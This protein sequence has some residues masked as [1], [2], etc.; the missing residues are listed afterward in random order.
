MKKTLIAFALA[1][2]TAATASA[3][4]INMSFE[5]GLL[6][7]STEPD[8]LAEVVTSFDDGD[9]PGPLYG[10]YHAEHFLKLTSGAA[11]IGTVASNTFSLEAGD[12]IEGV[13]AFTTTEADFGFLNDSASVVIL[14]H[15]GFTTSVVAT[16]WTASAF[17]VGLYGS[18][19]WQYWSFTAATPGTYS[20]N[21]LVQNTGDTLFD[22]YA[23]F[24]AV[25]DGGSALALLGLGMIGLG[26]VRRKLF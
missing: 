25:P 6:E 3:G 15:V 9:P 11:N 20:I 14:E 5:L 19:P 13:A 17:G 16:P 12:K 1:L 4:P 24:D 23:L 21:Y 18:T 22:S 8:A 7:W 2:S 26:A 10:P